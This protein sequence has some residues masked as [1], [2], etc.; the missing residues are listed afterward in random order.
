[1]QTLLSLLPLITFIGGLLIFKNRLRESAAL[2]LI[3][4]SFLAAF[5]MHSP[6]EDIFA[7]LLKGLLV[8]FDIVLIIFGALT[9]LYITKFTGVIASLENHLHRV[10]SDIR[11]QT[12][13]IAWFF[14]AFIEASAG[15][16]IPALI[17]SYF[18]LRIGIPAVSAI[19][20]AL[21]ANSIPVAFGAVGTPIKIGFYSYN[22]PEIGQNTA[23]LG[24]FISVFIPLMLVF[25]LKNTLNKP[26]KEFFMSAT[27]FALWAGIC[28][29][30]PFYFGLRLGL[31]FPSLVGSIVG[32]S[33]FLLTLKLPVFKISSHFKIKEPE[34]TTRI[35]PFALAITPYLFLVSFLVAAKFL[36]LSYL[37]RFGPDM[38]HTFHLFNPG[39]VFLAA[40][41]AILLAGRVSIKNL[42]RSGREASKK[43]PYIVTVIF[44]VVSLMQI[45]VNSGLALSA[46][47]NLETPA[48][49]YLAP[50]IGAFGAFIAGSATVSN[51]LFGPV[52]SFAAVEVG[53]SV[54]YILALQLLG[55][56]AGN[57]LAISNIVTAQS[58]VDLKGRE[59]QI[60]QKIFPW[61]ILYILLIFTTV[62]IK[63]FF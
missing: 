1:M 5:Y 28:F 37:V 39:A 48:L 15:F 4:A 54:S 12:I 58:A 2:S 11:I 60:I 30:V 61:T 23:V 32:I 38:T 55:A 26:F 56:T 46:F 35:L 17:T 6:T 13:L 53:L 44:L 10:S 8:S 50:I 62:T 22:M 42:E 49:P 25:I 45:M 24:A 29:A 33:V 21:V 47:K 7:S 36:P 40:A 18:L 9:F 3:I 31:E 63:N 20:L 51:L 57:M 34:E 41:A 14:G 59:K 16:G 27:P 19:V 43:I 52:Q